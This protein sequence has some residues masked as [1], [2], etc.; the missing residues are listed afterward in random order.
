[1][2]ALHQ[3]GE[4]LLAESGGS[5]SFCTGSPAESCTTENYA[6][7]NSGDA[8]PD[9]GCVQS[10]LGIDF[11]E[12]E[13]TA[14]ENQPC[15]GTGFFRYQSDSASGRVRNKGLSKGRRVEVCS[16]EEGY[17]GAWFEGVILTFTTGG[18]RC[19]IRYDKFVTDDGKPLVEEVWLH[20]EV[21]PIPPHIQLPLH[22]S[23]GDAVEA[24]DTDC[25]WRGV[26]VKASEG[27]EEDLWVV[28]F[29][30]TCTLK[31]YP[32]S[33]LRPAQEWL[34]GEWMLAPQVRFLKY[35]CL[36]PFNG[37]F[38]GFIF[39]GGFWGLIIYKR[40]IRR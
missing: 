28:Y 34:R 20:S 29:P 13:R 26:I 23:V 22:C 2:N 15:G 18:R 10:S 4:P 7:S 25:W 16:S 5:P 33:E 32:H 31:A 36:R 21:R 19:K 1:M 38:L 9:S 11:L 17:G 27:A 12:E 35:I 6:S 40:F 39:N 14:A 37:A 3:I 30:D 24:Y 8:G